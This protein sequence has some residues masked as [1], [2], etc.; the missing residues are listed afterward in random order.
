MKGWAC[1]A[2][3]FSAARAAIPRERQA[4]PHSRCAGERSPLRHDA[5][6]KKT[7]D[8]AKAVCDLRKDISRSNGR[9]GRGILQQR[10][11]PFVGRGRMCRH[12]GG[13]AAL[14]R[15][16]AG[17]SSFPFVQLVDA[18]QTLQT[19]AERGRSAS[20]YYLAGAVKSR[21]SNANGV[22]AVALDNRCM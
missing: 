4:T 1:Q 14:W 21:G 20:A 18:R 7:F 10:I 17:K 16:V 8:N 22:I 11:Y 13:V 15:K 9:L 12:K 6:H 5:A 19:F 2:A 3:G